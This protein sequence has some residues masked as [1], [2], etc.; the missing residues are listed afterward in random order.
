MLNVSI[1]EK[2]H[3][4][5]YENKLNFEIIILILHILYKTNDCK[6]LICI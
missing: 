4:Y 3:V 2:L 5:F 1:I 6:Q